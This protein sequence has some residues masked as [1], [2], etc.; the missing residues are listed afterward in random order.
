MDI[1]RKISYALRGAIAAITCVLGYIAGD[2]AM[3]LNLQGALVG[4]FISYILP[5][6]FY[7][8]MIAYARALR[9]KD[10]EEARS[11]RLIVDKGEEEDDGGRLPHLDSAAKRAGL[12]HIDITKDKQDDETRLEFWQKMLCYMI[13][14][15][16]TVGGGISLACTTTHIGDNLF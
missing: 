2:F 15:F 3:F 1:R 11:S 6:L 7:L 8:R 9:A 16:G 12:K 14:L 5:C 10:K 13:M 4:T